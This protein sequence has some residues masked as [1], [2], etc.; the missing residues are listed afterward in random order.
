[1]YTESGENK[2]LRGVV[3]DGLCVDVGN[4]DGLNLAREIANN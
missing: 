3:F 2:K 4:V 1:M